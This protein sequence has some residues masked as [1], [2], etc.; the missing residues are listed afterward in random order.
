MRFLLKEHSV[1]CGFEME[2]YYYIN[3]LILRRRSGPIAMLVY[4]NT[5]T[6]FF[7]IHT[8]PSNGDKTAQPDQ[9]QTHASQVQ[10]TSSQSTEM[11]PSSVQE[12]MLQRLFGIVPVNPVLL[13]IFRTVSSPS[14]PRDDG[15]VPL[16]ALL[17]NEIV[18]IF[19]GPASCI[20]VSSRGSV[21]LSKAPSSLGMGPVN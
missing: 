19:L 10:L 16:S 14:L 8:Q 17:C 11:P 9:T 15:T 1:G 2:D 21:L 6:P 3:L 7:N 20:L 5:K 13:Q 12:L 18:V 4:T